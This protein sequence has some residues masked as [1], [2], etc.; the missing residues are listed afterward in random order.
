MAGNSQAMRDVPSAP[1]NEVSWKP[2]AHRSPSPRITLRRWQTHKGPSPPNFPSSVACQ[3][4]S[5]PG[6]VQ[7]RSRL[8]SIA[9][10]RPGSARRRHMSA[11]RST[12]A[13][14]RTITTTC[15]DGGS[16]APVAEP[17]DSAA[18]RESVAAWAALDG[19]WRKGICHSN[20]GSIVRGDS[21][22]AWRRGPNKREPSQKESR[23][24]RLPCPVKAR[25]QARSSLRYWT[26]SATWALAME[27]ED[28]RS[29]MVRATLSTR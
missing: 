16:G 8:D 20:G 27:S 26:A 15:W 21:I 19:P 9:V 18:T 13:S 6:E 17:L 7:S 23:R 25:A 22:L 12:H 24:L 1:G 11:R 14:S 28:A 5:Q 4:R 29:A 3:P 10:E 2:S